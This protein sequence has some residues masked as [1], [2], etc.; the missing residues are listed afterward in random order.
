MGTN[1]RPGL[2]L[3]ARMAHKT[4]QGANRLSFLFCLAANKN[5]KGTTMEAGIPPRVWGHSQA[6]SRIH[7]AGQRRACL[8]FFVGGRKKK[9]SQ[10]FLSEGRRGTGIWLNSSRTDDQL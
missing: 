5:G 8:V 3:L 9:R 4:G 10:T 2:S 1:S 7:Q 6:P